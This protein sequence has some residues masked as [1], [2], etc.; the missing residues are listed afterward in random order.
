MIKKVLVT[1]AVSA[2]AVVGVATPAFAGGRA[3]S[4]RDGADIR[5]TADVNGRIIG[6]G[7]IDDEV[8]FHC[9][10][11]REHPPTEMVKEPYSVAMWRLTDYT[12]DVTGWSEDV[13]APLGEGTECARA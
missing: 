13:I 3:Q 1:C 9:Y 10:V 8:V 5:A 11:W 2:C 4:A 7:N 12:R 6:T